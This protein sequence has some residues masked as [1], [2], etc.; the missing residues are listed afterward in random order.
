MRAERESWEKKQHE[1]GQL[2]S[3]LQTV[4]VTNAVHTYCAHSFVIVSVNLILNSIS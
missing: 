2:A 1:V 3:E 4:R